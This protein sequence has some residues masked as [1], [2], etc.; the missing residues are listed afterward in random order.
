MS[1]I[2]QMKRAI[3]LAA[4]HGPFVRFYPEGNEADAADKVIEKADK[5]TFDKER[6]KVDQAEAVAKK[7]TVALA[8]SNDA[9]AVAQQETD[10]LKQKLADAETRAVEAGIPNMP[11][12]KESDYEDTDKELVRSINALKGQLA[13]KDKDIDDLKKL[14]EDFKAEG[15]KERTRKAS[16]VALEEVLTDLD[17]EF[18]ADTRNAA[19]E[20]WNVL[21]EEGKVPKGKPAMA[22]RLMTKCYKDAKAEAEAKA[23]EDEKTGVKLDAGSGGG[24]PGNLSGTQLKQGQS[25]DDAVK[26]L[27]SSA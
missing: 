22:T 19:L 12:L 25:L 6:Q 8:D 15:Q 18:G 20:K 16:D 26:Q 21:K 4:V 9:L 7:A 17:G 13:N 24:Q 14:A 5:E 11:D 3:R 1:R 10:N 2:T 23:K 27:K